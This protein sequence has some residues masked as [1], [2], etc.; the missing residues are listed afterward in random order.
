MAIG[1]RLPI[2]NIINRRFWTRKNKCIIKLNKKSATYWKSISAND[3]YEAKYQYL[4]DKPEKV[5][6]DHFNDPKT[7]VQ[8]SS[9]M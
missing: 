1:S 8:Y 3:P 9:N 7:F 2:P 6:L 4:I 5:G